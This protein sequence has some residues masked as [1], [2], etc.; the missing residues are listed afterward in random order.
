[1]GIAMPAQFMHAQLQQ[2]RKYLVWFDRKS[3]LHNP[4]SLLPSSDSRDASY[5]G[6]YE[7]QR[8]GAQ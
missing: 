1:M 2:R 3:C 8:Y 6:A 4:L 5:S 7:G